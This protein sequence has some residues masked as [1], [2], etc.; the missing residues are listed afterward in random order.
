MGRSGSRMTIFVVKGWPDV[1][2]IVTLVTLPL[3]LVSLA[4][5]FA[6]I[7]NQTL[8]ALRSTALS[9]LLRFSENYQEV[10]ATRRGLLSR[11]G[12]G[13]DTVSRNDC[14]TYFNR[15]WI[16]RQMEWD[17]FILGLIP[18]ETFTGWTENA[19]RHIDGKRDLTYFEA[20]APRTLSS[21]EVF[22]DY[23]LGNLYLRHTAC[24][25]FYQGLLAL[26]DRLQSRGV[27]LDSEA[28]FGEI[29]RYVAK[30]GRRR[31]GLR[32]RF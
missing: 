1:A 27:A 3:G 26:C 5:T 2:A 4:L 20:G 6:Q 22:A 29:A 11:A 21:R 10:S 23:V 25:Q 8:S 30:S 28:A 18:P 15:Y 13:G 32:L 19:V 14:M 16:L 24:R 12:R 31:P 17:Y 7:R 9:S